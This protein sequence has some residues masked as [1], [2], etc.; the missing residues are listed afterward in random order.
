M[1][2]GI[3]RLSDTHDCE[4]CGSSWADGAL[5][6]IDDALALELEPHAHCYDGTNYN[7]EDIFRKILEHLGHTVTWLNVDEPEVV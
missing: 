3:K 6:Y 1:D 5:V 2:I 7:D 4:T